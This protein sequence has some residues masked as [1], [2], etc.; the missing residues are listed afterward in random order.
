MW[1]CV[2]NF[3]FLIEQ[4]DTLFLRCNES[5]IENLYSLDKLVLASQVPKRCCPAVICCS[6]V[7]E[8]SFC[9]YS[10][11]IVCWRTEDRCD[12]ES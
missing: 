5:F 6:A 3:R 4:C 1:E 9:V 12:A 2:I 11:V 8:L 7:V 10:R